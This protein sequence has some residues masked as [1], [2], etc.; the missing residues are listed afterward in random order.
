MEIDILSKVTRIMVAVIEAKAT[1]SSSSNCK[2]S[3]SSSRGGG[4]CNHDICFHLL[5]L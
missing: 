1:S 3:N 5:T 2:I 4:G